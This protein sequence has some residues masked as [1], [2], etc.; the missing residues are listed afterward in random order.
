MVLQRFA[1]S[2]T[3]RLWEFDSPRLRQFRRI[4]WESYSGPQRIVSG[5]Q[6]A[7]MRNSWNIL[8]VSGSYVVK[9]AGVEKMPEFIASK[10]MMERT[11]CF[12]DR[13]WKLEKL[14]APQRSGSK[15]KLIFEDANSTG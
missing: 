1:K 6:K 8:S 3:E 14:A 11:Q 10:L 4:S 5:L 12:P 9:L 13:K 7:I 15:Q 2:P